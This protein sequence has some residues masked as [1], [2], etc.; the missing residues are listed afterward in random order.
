MAAASSSRTDRFEAVVQQLQ[1]EGLFEADTHRSKLACSRELP[2]CSFCAEHNHECVYTKVIR[3]PLT[4]KNLDAAEKRIAT[5]EALLQRFRASSG[6]SDP[7]PEVDDDVGP[8]GA[9]ASVKN[10]AQ[11]ASLPP[12][13]APPRSEPSLSSPVQIPARSVSQPAHSVSSMAYAAIPGP[14]RSDM[15]ESTQQDATTPAEHGD[16]TGSLTVEEGGGG[17]G[18][19]GSISGAALLHFLQNAADVKI[20][21]RSATK[22]AASPAS[23][24]ASHTAVTAD[25]ADKFVDAYF[26][27][28]HTMYPVVHEATFRAQLAEIVP[29][30][31]GAAWKLLHLVILGIGSMCMLGDVGEQEPTLIFYERAAQS[32]STATFESTSLTGIQAFILLAN[33]AQKLNHT[34][35][36]AVFL[37]IALRMSINFGLHTEASARGLSPFEQEL[38][39]RVWW[40]LFCFDCGAQLTFGHPSTMLTQG[41]DVATLVNVNDATFTPAAKT[42]PTG[43][44]LPTS[45]SSIIYQT[46]FHQVANSIV[47]TL[48]TSAPDTVTAS[49]ALHLCHDLDVLESTLPAYYCHR[50]PKWFDFGRQMFFWRTLNLRMLV[51]RSTFLRVALAGSE[52]VSVDEERAWQKCLSCA[53]QVIRSVQRFTDEQPR[54]CMEW[55]YCLHFVFPAIFIVLIALRVRPTHAD[56]SREWLKTIQ[57]AAN[58]V[59][60]VQFSLLKGLAQRCLTIITAVAN[61]PQ[62]VDVAPS[63]MDPFGL[64]RHHQQMQQQRQRRRVQSS[65]STTDDNSTVV[66]DDRNAAALPHVAVDADFAG[67]LEMLAAPGNVGVG[68]I[69][70]T[71]APPAEATTSYYSAQQPGQSATAARAHLTPQ[72]HFHPGSSTQGGMYHQSAPTQP[73]PQHQAHQAHAGHHQHYAVAPSSHALPGNAIGGGGGLMMGDLDALLSYFAPAMTP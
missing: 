67:F 64:A 20:E 70:F 40:T 61:V 72:P 1:D 17:G 35:A 29:R 15:Q 2:D 18:Y 32:V 59:E 48:T 37:G 34:A 4:R 43:S 6:D 19:L 63:D 23:T 27:V 8:R 3:T 52:P 33:F 7:T 69:G 47:H 53:S 10:E 13:P 12:A 62:Q 51:L 71:A 46:Y 5:L 24:S 68:A 31:S 25:Q 11:T 28:F 36:G 50:E 30:P 26:R 54:S 58:T 38:R 45:N 42:R 49:M 73:A 14:A 56:A 66:G 65:A 16:G 44:T 60:R 55:W 21:A 9:A 57:F 39:R 41:V 22:S